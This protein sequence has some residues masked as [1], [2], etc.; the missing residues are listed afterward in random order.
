MPSQGDRPAKCCWTPIEHLAQKVTELQIVGAGVGFPGKIPL[1]SCL[2]LLLFPFPAEG[3]YQTLL[4]DL[5]PYP[6]YAATL[7]PRRPA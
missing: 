6:G 3:H 7:N 4:G 2:F 1:P 5:N